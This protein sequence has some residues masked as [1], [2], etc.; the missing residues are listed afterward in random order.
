MQ[1]MN[2]IP[3]D[4]IIEAIKLISV[5]LGVA[6]GAL[7]IYAGRVP[8][9]KRDLKGRHL[10]MKAFFSE[11]GVNVAPLQFESAFAQAVG[12]EK[13]DSRDIRLILKQQCPTGFMS[14]Y[15]WSRKYLKVDA[16]E[17]LVFKGIIKTRFWRNCLLVTN[18]STYVVLAIA[19]ILLLTYGAPG[20]FKAGD[21]AHFASSILLACVFVG[22]ALLSLVN[23]SQI[24][25]AK[26]LIEA[27]TQ[28]LSNDETG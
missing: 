11:G 16:R 17:T 18:F 9:P 10:A 23:A 26:K 1:F 24:Q 15:S 19:A 27:Q 12:H 2:D 3:F 13:F 28:N 22:L 21:W 20:F 6:A 4:K 7:K 8:R 25:S 14:E 5:P